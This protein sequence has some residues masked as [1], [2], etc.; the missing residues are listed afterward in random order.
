MR[1]RA[2]AVAL[3]VALITLG[4]PL[5]ASAALLIPNGNPTGANPASQWNGSST[6]VPS[7]ASYRVAGDCPWIIP[8]LNAEGF[9]AANL[10]TINTVALNGDITLGTYV[11][12][13]NTDPAITQGAFNFPAEGKLGFGGANIGLGYN[14]KAGDPTGAGVHWIQVIHTNSPSAFGTGNAGGV[15]VGG[16]TNYIDNGYNG[17]AGNGFNPPT[18]NNPFYDDLGAGYAANSTDFVDAPARVIANGVDWQAQVFVATWAPNNANDRTK[19]GTIT[20]Y[21]GVWWGFQLAVAAGV[22]DVFLVPEPTTVVMWSVFISLAMLVG[23]LR[24]RHPPMQLAG[25]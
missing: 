20:L 1:V 18:P 4:L 5:G 11:P 22:T 9:N 10:W 7:P 17:N 14:P 25:G 24:R 15:P 6:L 19:G 16:Y 8:A 2:L 23:H 12:W 21:D 3:A 13:V